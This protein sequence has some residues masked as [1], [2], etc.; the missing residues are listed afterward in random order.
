MQMIYNS[1]NY[2]VVEFPPQNGH[3]V[4]NAG[5]YEIVDKHAQRELFIEGQ[6]AMNFREQVKQLIEGEPS[7]DEVDEFLEQFGDL[8]QQPVVLH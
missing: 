3:R 6:M 2:C 4:M 5:G 1:P 7:L 8:M